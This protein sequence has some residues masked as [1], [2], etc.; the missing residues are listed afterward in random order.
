MNLKE[1]LELY[2]LQNRSNL[3]IILKSVCYTKRIPSRNW[4]ILVLIFLSKCLK[5]NYSKSIL[6][7]RNRTLECVNL[8]LNYGRAVCYLNQ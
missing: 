5:Y 6:I 1:V 7:T 2:M 8:K 3:E 4:K